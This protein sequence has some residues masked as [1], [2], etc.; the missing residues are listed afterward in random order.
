VVGAAEDDLAGHVVGHVLALWR[1]RVFLRALGVR[2]ELV[3]GSLDVP[4]QGAAGRGLAD[5]CNSSHAIAEVVGVLE[6]D[7]RRARGG[8]CKNL[9][10]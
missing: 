7:G 9:A 1:V 4:D 8:G 2:G 6:M 10:L 3:G 5:P